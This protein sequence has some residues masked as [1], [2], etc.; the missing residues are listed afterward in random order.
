[1]WLRLDLISHISWGSHLST[2]LYIYIYIY[3]YIGHCSK[4][5]TVKKR[6][7]QNTLESNIESHL[8]LELNSNFK[9]NNVLL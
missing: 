6:T 1:M 3:I 8:K 5:N 4:Q 2:C 7:T 9:L